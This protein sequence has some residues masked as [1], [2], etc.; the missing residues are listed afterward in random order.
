[1]KMNTGDLVEMWNP[2][3]SK[4]IIG[5]VVQTPSEG[6]VK[7]LLDGEVQTGSVQYFKKIN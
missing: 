6:L 7:V 4:K 2:H 1:M 5:I 3:I